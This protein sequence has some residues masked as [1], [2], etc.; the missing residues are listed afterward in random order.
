MCFEK[1]YRWE[2]KL[3][4][5]LSYIQIICHK[6][7]C[8]TLPNSGQENADKDEEGDACDS[9]DDDDGIQDA[10]VSKISYVIMQSNKR[11]RYLKKKKERKKKN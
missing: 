7:N 2:H 1:N 4:D 10:R 8:P 11:D 6:D 9:D 5:I 3:D